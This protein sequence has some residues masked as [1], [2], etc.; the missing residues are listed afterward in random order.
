MLITALEVLNKI[1]EKGFK[2]YIVGGFVRDSFLGIKSLDVDIC[3]SATPKELVSIFKNTKLKNE[4]YGS[5]SL[6]Y[7]KI[8]FEITTFRKE[9][10]YVEARKPIEIKYIKD[11]EED[12]KR[13][14]FTMNTLC[15]DKE[16]N[17][18]DKLNSIED[19]RSKTI[20]TVGEPN[21]KF[22]ED[23]L[24]ILRAIRF[25]SQLG[26]KLD[27]DTQ[28]AIY[29][30]RKILKKL[31]FHRRKQELDKIFLGEF[32]ASAIKKIIELELDKQLEIK[33][34]ENL[35]L[36]SDINAIWAQLD[37]NIDDWPF[38]KIEKQTIIKI[39]ELL[40]KEE[41]DDYTL[42]KEGLY[43]CELVYK[44]KELDFQSLSKRYREL[45]IKNKKEINING[46]EVATILEK[47]P[48]NFIK[49][50]LLDIE[51]QIINKKLTNNKNKIT[52]YIIKTHKNAHLK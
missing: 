8:R 44:I 48:G 13:R 50:I 23:A 39:K 14:D 38:T 27:T 41:I 9:I 31:T 20:K 24:R 16:N 3:T 5:I 19:I 29:N 11:L 43:I 46:I 52:E 17:L 7:K 22:V 25:I 33:N 6:I 2:A 15:L 35:K 37:I 12:I 21:L 18:I 32:N 47:E 26:F 1:E 49:D 10:K 40:K 51:K 42:Y 36:I 45:I 34:I 4:T 30:N 28:N